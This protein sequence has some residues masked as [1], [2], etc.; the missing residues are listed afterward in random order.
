MV[1]TAISTPE[2]KYEDI[3]L[4]GSINTVIFKE[5]NFS[6]KKFFFLT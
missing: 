2:M 6:K 4:S 5:Q 3:I 1:C